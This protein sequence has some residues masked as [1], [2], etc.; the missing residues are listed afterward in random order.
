VVEIISEHFKLRPFRN[1]DA[2]IF[3]LG[4]N[5]QR[6]ERDTTIPIP[7]T[8]D[9]IIWWIGFITE[10]AARMP[11]TELAFCSRNR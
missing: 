10:A 2:H 1:E 8:L 7:W 5:T 3:H 6:I 4:I 9:S 11:L